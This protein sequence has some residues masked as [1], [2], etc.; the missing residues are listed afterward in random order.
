MSGELEVGRSGWRGTGVQLVAG[1]PEG[2][3]A[4]GWSVLH[5]QEAEVGGAVLEEAQ[6][7]YQRC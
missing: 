5:A 1:A 6:N 2:I 4:G 3:A 7:V